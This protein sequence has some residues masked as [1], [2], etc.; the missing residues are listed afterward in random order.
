MSS[1]SQSWR[2]CS[3]KYGSPGDILF[4]TV[5]GAPPHVH[6][7][8]KIEYFLEP[9]NSLPPAKCTPISLSNSLIDP[10]IELPAISVREVDAVLSSLNSSVSS[11]VA[12]DDVDCKISTVHRKPL[13]LNYTS[14][15]SEAVGLCSVSSSIPY[16]D[17]FKEDGKHFFSAD[18]KLS[19]KTPQ[20]VYAVNNSNNSAARRA[21]SLS[22]DRITESSECNNTDSGISSCALG[23]T[24]DESSARNKAFPQDERSLSDFSV[25]GTLPLNGGVTQLS[26]HDSVKVLTLRSTDSLRLLPHTGLSVRSNVTRDDCAPNK[27]HVLAMRTVPTVELESS[28]HGLPLPRPKQL[29]RDRSPFMSLDL[30]TQAPINKPNIPNSSMSDEAEKY[31]EANL[32]VRIANQAQFFPSRS[33]GSLMRSTLTVQPLQSS[34]NSCPHPRCG[35]RYQAELALLRHL[36]KYHCEPIELPHRRRPA[37]GRR[38]QR[39]PA[40]E[41]RSNNRLCGGSDSSTDGTLKILLEPSS[42]LL[43]QLHTS[44]SVEDTAFGAR[45]ITILPGGD[46]RHLI[47]PS[48]SLVRAIPTAGTT[49]TATSASADK[50]ESSV[51]PT[52]AQPISVIGGHSVSSK[53]SS[54]PTSVNGTGGNG[55]RRCFVLQHNGHKGNLNQLN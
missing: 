13:G 19:A 46:N 28:V 51:Q 25:N 52:V 32:S 43:T 49:V 36:H 34:I 4:S 17:G 1:S 53:P 14:R 55:L 18:V 2:R 12:P 8:Q 54:T 35:R 15:C 47:Q 50:A 41:E 11:T 20:C 31:R 38:L 22:I 42:F 26:K 48:G 37:P 21:F 6:S 30:A 44:I 45:T 9:G 40:S 33:I 10:N 29:A 24:S 16:D 7:P 3:Q 23:H 5:A 27:K 39:R